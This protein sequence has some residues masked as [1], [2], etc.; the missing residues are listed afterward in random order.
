MEHSP[1]SRL[2]EYCKKHFESN[3]LSSQLG[4]GTDG[5]VWLTQHRTAVKAFFSER[6]FK[7]ELGCFLRLEKHQVTSIFGYAIPR[8]IDADQT[9]LVIEMTTVE[10]PY[11]LDF[12]KA[13]LDLKPEYTSHQWSD[14]YNRVRQI[15]GDRYEEVMRVVTGLQQYGIYYYD[16]TL[17]NVMP[18]NWNPSLDE[19]HDEILPDDYDK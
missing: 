6:Q 17:N 10:P 4:E 5:A 19:E 7:A 11:L 8:L 3:S 18:D 12:G 9:L 2:H 1:L 13:Y 14:L 15:Y 16:I